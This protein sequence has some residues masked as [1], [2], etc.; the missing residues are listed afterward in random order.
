MPNPGHKAS[1]LSRCCGHA[2]FSV[3]IG[4]GIIVCNCKH[5]RHSVLFCSS[6]G[7][8][9]SFRAQHGHSSLCRGVCMVATLEPPPPPLLFA[10]ELCPLLLWFFEEF[11]STCMFVCL[12]ESPSPI[13]LETPGRQ[14]AYLPDSARPLA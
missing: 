2:L 12:P 4:K 5:G 9:F 10:T 8:D 7:C 1:T 11:T 3:S 6:H 14:G 13:R